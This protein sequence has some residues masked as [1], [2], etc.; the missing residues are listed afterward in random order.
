MRELE[1]I[2]KERAEKQAQEV[3]LSNQPATSNT[4]NRFQ[5]RVKTEAE[6][7]DRERDIALGNPLLNPYKNDETKRRCI[8]P[9]LHNQSLLTFYR[10]DDDVVF[11]NQARG[12]E[13]RGKKEFVNVCNQF[14]VRHLRF[15]ESADRSIGPS[16]FR[17][18]QAIHGK[19]KSMTS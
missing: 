11:R 7:E 6:K 14:L 15:R 1:K 13:N 19:S 12:T 10:W 3:A 16:T 8:R 17:L 9:M 2:K 5:E 18:S 4:S